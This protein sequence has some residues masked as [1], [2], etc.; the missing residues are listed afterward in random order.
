M[1]IDDPHAL[2]LQKKFPWK[3]VSSGKPARYMDF[4]CRGAP[5]CYEEVASRHPGDD[6]QVCEY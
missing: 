2:T 4:C 6:K 1:N 3:E 5:R